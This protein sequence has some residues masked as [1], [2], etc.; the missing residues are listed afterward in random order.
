MH[1]PRLYNPRTVIGSVFFAADKE[2][3]V[4]KLAVS[5]SADF[6]DGLPRVSL[7]NVSPCTER[8]STY[9]RVQVNEDRARNVLSAAGLGEKGLKRATLDGFLAFGV[10]TSVG[11]QSML[12]EVSERWIVSD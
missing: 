12:Q 7:W 2:F 1:K 6:V 8:V 10:G 5:A 4:E 3:G 9:R 11:F